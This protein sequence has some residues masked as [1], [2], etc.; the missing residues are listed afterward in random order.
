[1]ELG[2]VVSFQNFIMGKLQGVSDSLQIVCLWLLLLPLS[3]V[4]Y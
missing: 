1:M 2:S 3:V 4:K